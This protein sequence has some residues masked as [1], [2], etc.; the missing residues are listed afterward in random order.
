MLPKCVLCAP[1]REATT[2][3]GCYGLYLGPLAPMARGERLSLW[4]SCLATRA[5]PSPGP[6]PEKTA[7][8]GDKPGP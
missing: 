4:E 6:S 2:Q 7:S 1:A 8:L 5:G 3:E